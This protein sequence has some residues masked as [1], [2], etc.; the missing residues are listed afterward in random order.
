M[1]DFPWQH[2]RWG[3]HI[4]RGH[5]RP[6]QMVTRNILLF[7]HPVLWLSWATALMETSAR[8]MS[9]TFSDRQSDKPTC[10]TTA[11]AVP[12]HMR[13]DRAPCRCTIVSLCSH[14]AL[15]LSCLPTVTPHILL[16]LVL[17]EC[18]GGSRG[19]TECGLSCT[20]WLSNPCN[21]KQKIL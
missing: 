19:D 5:F 3:R 15:L 18:K 13:A 11:G 14:P 6:S 8:H 21:S 17:I 4:P 20:Q 2:W 10:G 1:N 16:L 7:P 12:H 9:M